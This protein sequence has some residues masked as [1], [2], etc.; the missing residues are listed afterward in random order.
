MNGCASIDQVDVIE[1]VET[2]NA[3]AVGGTLTCNTPN[4]IQLNGGSTTPGVSF[5]WSGPGFSSSDE[6]PTV[7]EPGTYVLTVTAPNGCSNTANAEVDED[8]DVPDASAVGG[9]LTCNTPNGIQLNGGSTT[10]G[11]SFSWSGPGFSSSDEDPT[12]T[13]PGT[14]VLTVTAPNGCSNTPNADVTDVDVP[15]ASAV[16]GTLTCNTPNGIQLN[17][18]STTPGVSFSWSGPGFSSS[19]EVP[20]VT[21]PGTYVLT[22]TAPNGCSNTANAEVDEDVDVPDASAVGGTLT[23][24]TPNGI[25]L[26]GGSTTPGVSFSWSGPGFSSSDEDTHRDGAGH[27]CLDRHRSQ[28]LQQHCERR[29]GRGC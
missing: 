29:S 5:S 11:V 19:D 24:N 22:V 6:D 4:G 3:S 21:E 25:Q 1:D 13:E 23:C 28:R 2:P 12:V 10:P 18:G 20:T 7:T 16:G 14:Y 27:L 15:D 8:V 9:T 17:G 26:N